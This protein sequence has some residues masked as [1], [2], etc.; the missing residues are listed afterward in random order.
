M[1]T[2]ITEDRILQLGRLRGFWKPQR[3]PPFSVSLTDIADISLID[4]GLHLLIGIRTVGNETTKP[5]YP[6]DPQTLAAKIAETAG[7]T[8]PPPVGR[9]DH[10]AGA[11]GAIGLMACLIAKPWIESALERH[12]GVALSND[13]ISIDAALFVL[14]SF[15]ALFIII[16]LG[17]MLAAVAAVFFMPLYASV[18][19]AANWFRLRPRRRLFR[20]LGWKSRPYLWLAGLVYGS[21]LRVSAEQSS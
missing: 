13:L 15:P 9:L 8:S 17:T 12:F 18:E 4:N 21:D 19:E 5:L 14:L 1:E 3:D 10:V 2:L 7:L 6:I 16:A 20:W 11:C